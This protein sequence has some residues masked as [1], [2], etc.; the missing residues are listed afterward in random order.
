MK[1]RTHH[2]ASSESAFTFVDLLVSVLLLAFCAVMILPALGKTGTNSALAKC[3]ANLRQ[4]NFGWSM[5]AANNRG[6][7]ADNSSTLI[8]PGTAWVTGNAQSSGAT[9]VYCYG[10][11]D[12]N[13]IVRGNLWPYVKSLDAYR[14]GA[15]KRVAPAGA[16]FAGQPIRRSYSMNSWMASGNAYGSSP[17]VHQ[18]H[19]NESEIRFPSRTFV[20]IDEDFSSVNDGLFLVDMGSGPGLVDAPGRQHDGGYT[21]GFADGHVEYRKLVDPRSLTWQITP[22]GKNDNQDYINLTNVTTSVR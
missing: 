18:M 14:C 2:H 7:L 9:G 12:T 15:D 22:I 19:F 8:C 21:L 16:P 13:G 17:N 5:Y 11:A 4:L 10:G 6:A 1:V 20:F 3:M